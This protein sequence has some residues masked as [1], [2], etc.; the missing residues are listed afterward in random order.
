MG[1]LSGKVAI[2]TGAA[3]GIGAAYAKALA[4]EGAK[5][6]L[7]DLKAPDAVVKEITAA[8]GEA[9]SLACDVTDARAVANLAA[10]TE[11]AFGGIHILVNNAGIFAS[12]ALKPM[13]E[14]DSKEWDLVMAVNVRGSFECAKAVLPVMRRQKYGKI[15]N[16][17]SGTVFKG[18]P[19]LL[20]Y[21]S[22]KGAVVA[23]TRALAR[24][25]G[26]DGIRVNC[27]APGLTM[28]E[29]V[30]ANSDWAGAVVANN[31]ASRCIKRDA[32]PEDLTG[33]VVFLASAESD[34]MSGQ[35]MV[36]D[37]GSVT[38]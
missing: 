31:V 17:A 9:L 3:Q 10:E 7:C 21:V 38:H 12:L 29:G 13:S 30:L 14:I 22:S 26:G 20:H 35:T 5:L 33:A 24:E 25:V 8:G 37:G 4:A 2:V 1:R 18:A 16:I 23:M 11:R 6:G 27:L 15:I 28:S 34:F 19:M 36:V 32:T